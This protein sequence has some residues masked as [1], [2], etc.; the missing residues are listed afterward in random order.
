MSLETFRIATLLGQLESPKL[1]LLVAVGSNVDKV[2]LAITL[3]RAIQPENFAA[4]A[5]EC[6]GRCF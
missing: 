5:R 1:L 3:A 4:Q 2:H 6:T